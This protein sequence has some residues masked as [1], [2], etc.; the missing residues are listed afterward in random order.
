MASRDIKNLSK[1]AMNNR[2]AIFQLAKELENTQKTILVEKIQNTQLFADLS[3]RMCKLRNE[4]RL[5]F[6]EMQMEIVFNMFY[7]AV[8]EEILDLSEYK[9]PNSLEY[10]H[11][12]KVACLANSIKLPTNEQISYCNH[13]VRYADT[14]GTNLEH[15]SYDNSEIFIHIIIT[16]IICIR[17]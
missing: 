6:L 12:F 11:I 1:I 7:G 5:A 13:L 3:H 17:L 16:Y 4:D 9:L 2:H 14:V 8:V 15:F 10:I